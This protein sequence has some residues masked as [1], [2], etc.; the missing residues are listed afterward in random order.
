MIAEIENL[1]LGLGPCAEYARPLTQDRSRC[2][3]GAAY[4]SRTL[5]CK[6]GCTGI[7]L[8]LLNESAGWGEVT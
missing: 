4:Q 1:E 6:S 3:R 2:L 8:A 7:H 5:V